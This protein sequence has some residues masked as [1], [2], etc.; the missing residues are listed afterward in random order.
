[1]P[2]KKLRRPKEPETSREEYLQ[3]AMELFA[4]KGFYLTSVDDIAKKAGRSK[5]GFYHH[6]KSKN[7]LLRALFS[8]MMHAFGNTLLTEI[9]SGKPV[10]QAFHNYFQSPPVQ[11]AMTSTY[12]RAIAELYA[13]ALRDRGTRDML[14][15]FHQEAISLFEQVFEICRARKE[16]AFDGPSRELAEMIYHE[17]RGSM[18]INIILYEGR[19]LQR[20]FESYI[21][22]TL[23]AL[24][25]R[26]DWTAKP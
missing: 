20:Q 22:R 3:A 13:M 16:V 9:K 12:L 11:S 5:G 7:A 8:K 14:L 23:Q 15:D 6:F 17:V 21:Q 25:T 2:S 4:K 10:D 18:L 19:G 26:S 24:Q 1:M